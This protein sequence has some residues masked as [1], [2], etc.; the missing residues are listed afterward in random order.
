MSAYH[1]KGK[2]GRANGKEKATTTPISRKAAL[3]LEAM[4]QRAKEGLLALCVEVGSEALELMFE[5]ALEEKIGE[6]G[7][8]SAE[9]CGFSHGFETRQVTLGGR[10]VRTSRPRPRTVD[11]KGSRLRHMNRSMTVTFRESAIEVS[12]TTPRRGKRRQSGNQVLRWTLAGPQEAEG[13][14]RRVAG[15]HK[16]ALVRMRLPGGVPNAAAS[17]R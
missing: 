6:K 8:Y 4:R 3:R 14:F 13:R 11:G 1:S 9:R 5:S 10:K 16:L 7:K 2:F 15:Y 17:Y 12:R